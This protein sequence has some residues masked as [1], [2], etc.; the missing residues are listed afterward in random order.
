FV[1]RTEHNRDYTTSSPGCLRLLPVTESVVLPPDVG[2]APCPSR[3]QFRQ[4]ASSI[5]GLFSAALRR[6]KPSKNT[7]RTRRFSTRA[8]SPTAFFYSKRQ[9]Q[10]H[11]LIRARQGSGGWDFRGGAVL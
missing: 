3:H 8:T 11:G 5:R 9:G 2:A 1:S 10:G 4:K 7:R 6:E